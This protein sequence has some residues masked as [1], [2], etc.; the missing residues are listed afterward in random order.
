LNEAILILFFAIIAGIILSLTL[1]P[2]EKTQA[3][4]EDNKV[5]EKGSVED[6]EFEPDDIDRDI[7]E[8]P[9]DC[10]IYDELFDDI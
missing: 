9:D 10:L 1:K 5:F 8:M 3:P 2:R 6:S 7:D 4:S